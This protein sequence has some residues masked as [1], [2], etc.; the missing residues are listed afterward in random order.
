VLGAA[1]A[2][3]VGDAAGDEV[4]EAER[5]GDVAVDGGRRE[6]VAQLALGCS[7]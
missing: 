6:E 1:A 2:V 7:C 4:G 5:L 3:A